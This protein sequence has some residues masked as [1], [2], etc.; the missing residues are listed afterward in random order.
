MQNKLLHLIL[1]QFVADKYISFVFK[2]IDL[3]IMG[4]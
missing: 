3:V 4:K 2:H 1:M